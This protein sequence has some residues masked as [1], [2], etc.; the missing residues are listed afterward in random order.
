MFVSLKD[1]LTNTESVSLF[2]QANLENSMKRGRADIFPRHINEEGTG[3]HFPASY[4]SWYGRGTA[5]LFIFK[6]FQNLLAEWASVPRFLHFY[7]S[8]N[9][10]PVRAKE[11]SM[12]QILCYVMLAACSLGMSSCGINHSQYSEDIIPWV[13]ENVI[14]KWRVITLFEE[15]RNKEFIDEYQCVED[16]HEYPAFCK[17]ASWASR[18]KNRDVSEVREDIKRI[19]TKSAEYNRNY[20][21]YESYLLGRDYSHDEAEYYNGLFLAELDATATNV[22]NYWA[23]WEEYYNEYALSHTEI[24]D[25]GI[26]SNNLGDKYTGYYVIYALTGTDGEVKYAL[27]SITEYDDDSRYEYQIVATADSLR[28]IN[29]YLE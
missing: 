5:A 14:G 7:Y 21:I 3:G 19:F 11:F 10:V 16:T 15:Q 9:K 26:D 23:P 8:G 17:L 28:E 27:V 29:Q 22:Y 13:Y 18:Y 6:V 25:Q 24:L 12:K 2:S 1:I 20:T 4:H